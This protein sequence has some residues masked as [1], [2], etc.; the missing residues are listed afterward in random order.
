MRRYIL[1]RLHNVCIKDG[2]SKIW[3][4]FIQIYHFRSFVLSVARRCVCMHIYMIHV[5][6]F[7]QAYLF[8]LYLMPSYISA[9]S[10]LEAYLVNHRILSYSVFMKFQP[11]FVEQCLYEHSVLDVSI[12]SPRIKWT[13]LFSCLFSVNLHAD[14]IPH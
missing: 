3:L 8:V 4:R 11:L 1:L 12:Q 10:D 7:L 14:H 13:N 6:T 9:D 2:H 5:S